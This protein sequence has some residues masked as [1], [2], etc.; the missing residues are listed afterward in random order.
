MQ[1]GIFDDLVC[2][3]T[4]LLHAK[5]MEHSREV[6][7]VSEGLGLEEKEMLG[8]RHAATIQEALDFAFGIQGK[9]AKVGVINCGGDTLPKLSAF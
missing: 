3:A 9:E 8:F 7:C 4:L 5:I 2:A 1:K 6:I